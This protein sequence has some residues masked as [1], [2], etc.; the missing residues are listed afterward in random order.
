MK[1]CKHCASENLKY[2]YSRITR[3]KGHQ[4]VRAVYFCL[5][6]HKEIEII[7]K[8]EMLP[9]FNEGEREWGN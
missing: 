9:G 4:I 1:K 5:T 2:S 7:Q 6:C 3:R 8:V